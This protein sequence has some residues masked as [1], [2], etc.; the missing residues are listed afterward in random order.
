M[1]DRGKDVP[2]RRTIVGGRPPDRGDAGAGVPRGIEVLLKKAAVDPAFKDL[3]L[4]DPEEA[5]GSI[6]LSLSAVERSVLASV[7]RDQLE[8]MAER[9]EVPAEHRGV[10]LGRVAATMLTIVAGTTMACAPP[11]IAPGGAVVEDEP[12]REEMPEEPGERPELDPDRPII[13][14][15]ITIETESEK[16]DPGEEPEEPED[17][18]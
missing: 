12:P 9:M 5:A 14:A 7:P 18:R 16:V 6:G 8:G 4:A 1:S 11:A 15:G 2:V 10:F 3:L 17:P 13:V